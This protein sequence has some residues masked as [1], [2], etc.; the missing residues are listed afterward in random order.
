MPERSLSVS[1]VNQFIKRLIEGSAVLKRVLVEGEISG[2]RFAASGHL[3]FSLK[4][5]NSEI[6]CV[7]W[8]SAAAKLKF[9]PENGMSVMVSGSVQVYAKGGSYQII[10]TKIEQAGLGTLYIEYERLRRE[11]ESRGWFNPEK[12][13]KIPAEINRIGVVT[14]ASGAAVHDIISVI[15]RRNPSVGIL[16]APASV[17]GTGAAQEIADAVKRLNEHGGIDVIIVGRGGGSP[18]DLNAFNEMPVLQAVHDSKI[19]VISAV[20][21]ETD[22]LLSDFTADLRAPTPTAAAELVSEDRAELL[23]SIELLQN[24]LTERMERR[25]RDLMQQNDLLAQRLQ[26][27]SPE[28]VLVRNTGRCALLT[29]QLKQSMDNRLAGAQARL[30]QLTEALTLLNPGLRLEKGWVYVT[31]ADGRPVISA[32][33]AVENTQLDLHFADGTVK[34]RPEKD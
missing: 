19:P 30:K 25:I 27:S 8:R 20:G 13:R 12:K 26:A 2:C 10:V 18:Q 29:V 14:S 34:V 7:M 32:A 23:D 21:H 3:Y 9:M 4:D 33:R 16:L 1:Q 31:G 24:R 22:V 6:S 15:A 11:L 5:G 28:S 17:Q